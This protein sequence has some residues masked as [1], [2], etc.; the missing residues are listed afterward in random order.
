MYDTNKP[1]LVAEQGYPV[2]PINVPTD[3]PLKPYFDFY[4]QKYAFVMVKGVA[5]IFNFE[6]CQFEEL[7]SV[8]A[9][10]NHKIIQGKKTIK[11]YDEW[12]DSFEYRRTYHNARFY[13]QQLN[14]KVF[15]IWQ[16]WG[17]TPA[18]NQ[19]EWTMQ[20]YVEPWL[21]HIRSVLCSDKEEQYTYFIKWLAHFLQ[22]PE[23]K[24]GVAVVLQSGQGFG[25]GLWASFMQKI[26][27]D[28]Y[29]QRISDPSLVAGGFSGHLNNKL[30]VFIDEAT[31]GGDKRSQGRLKSI[32]SER[33]LSIENKHKDPYDVE[34][35]AR[36]MIASNSFY[37]VPIEPDDRRFFV[38]DVTTD[39]PSRE[40][41]SVL[42]G[43]LND[44]ESKSVR[45]VMR[46]LLDIDLS[47]F[48]VFDFPN[49]V[50][51]EI[52]KSESAIH[53]DM[54]ISFIMSAVWG[55]D[56]AQELFTPNVKASNLYE[57]FLAWKNM[58][59]SFRAAPSSLKS[60]AMQYERMGFQSIRKR[61]GF[62]YNISIGEAKKYLKSIGLL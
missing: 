54:Y 22:K 44:P 62:Y 51:R 58:H 23:E 12:M 56:Q 61:D 1:F 13:P 49:S 55:E 59:P 20:T 10:N 57:A 30:F 17:L 46:Y 32:I 27:G 36:F 5:H 2:Y 31:W 19:D 48:S 29:T 38:P 28:T 47:D 9:M 6:L 60:F 41:F 35:Y 21:N 40:Y 37:P 52:L 25:K 34:H 45:Y 14:E 4:N 7:P 24:P 33:T 3:E 50:K 43:L 26:V 16:G 11:P 39:K 15:N 18:S 8:R 53:N 42:W